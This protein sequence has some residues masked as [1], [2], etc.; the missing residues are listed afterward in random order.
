MVQ[1]SRARRREAHGHSIVSEEGSELSSRIKDRSSASV[2]TE[3]CSYAD[4][5]ITRSGASF[6]TTTEATQR[7][8]HTLSH[9]LDTRLN[10]LWRMRTYTLAVNSFAFSFPCLQFRHE[11]IVTSK[12][13][14]TREEG[15][16]EG[17]AG[18]TVS[19]KAPDASQGACRRTRQPSPAPSSGPRSDWT[20]RTAS[21]PPLSCSAPF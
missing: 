5:T 11:T 17:A 4:G 2:E 16:S 21:Y 12:S 18:R 7:S 19:G 20:A 14:Y 13:R 3:S 6:I 15:W 8:S 9:C 10:M 1:P